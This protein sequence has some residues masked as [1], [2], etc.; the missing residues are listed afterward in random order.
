MLHLFMLGTA[1]I[2]SWPIVSLVGKFEPVRLWVTLVA[3]KRARQEDVPAVMEWAA[4]WQGPA[5]SKRR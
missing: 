2:C 3:L 5:R 1:G 4:K